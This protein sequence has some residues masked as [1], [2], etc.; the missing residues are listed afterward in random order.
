MQLEFEDAAGLRVQLQTLGLCPAPAP[1]QHFCELGLTNEMM[2][3][4]LRA[5]DAM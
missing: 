1:L 5:K 4:P 2:N 3:G